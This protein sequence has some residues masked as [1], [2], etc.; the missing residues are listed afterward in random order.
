MPSDNQ[1]E[2][3]KRTGLYFLLGI[4]VVVVIVTAILVRRLESDHIVQVTVP[5]D[6]SP[7]VTP[8]AVHINLPSDRS[9]TLTPSAPAYTIVVKSVGQS[10]VSGTATFEDVAGVVA[11]RLHFDGLEEESFSPAEI[12]NGSCAA[13]TALAYALVAP[14]AGESETDLLINLEQFNTQKPLAV[15]LYRSVQDR[16]VIA[17]GDIP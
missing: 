4:A 17:C 1:G 6:R 3:R 5:P 16:T 15:I 2:G 13:P 8:S 11:I 7:T 9:P 12:H 14:E 10:G